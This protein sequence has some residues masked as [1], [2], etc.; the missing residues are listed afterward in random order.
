MT[1]CQHHGEPCDGAKFCTTCNVQIFSGY[2]SDG[3]YCN[4]HKPTTWDAD[5][6]SMTSEE[7]DNQD[8]MFWTQWEIEDIDCDCP[9]DCPCRP[10]MESLQELYDADRARSE[11]ESAAINSW[12]GPVPR[13]ADGG[14]HWDITHHPDGTITA[15]PTVSPFKQEDE[16]EDDG[17]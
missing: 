15:T 17:E 1:T 7:Y 14:S 4:G 6:A 8:E 5:I 10:S 3:D 2:W 13:D 11:A 12:T 16:D 9:D